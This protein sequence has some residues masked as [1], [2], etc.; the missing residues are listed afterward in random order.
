MKNKLIIFLLTII[1]LFHI[2]FAQTVKRSR[3]EGTI[4][5]PASNVM[6]NGNLTAYADLGGIITSE[7]LEANACIGAGIGIAEILQFNVQTSFI[8]FSR[9]GPTEGHLQA[10]IPG[11]DRLRFF[12]FAFSGDLYLST[13]LDTLDPDADVT[14]PEYNPYPLLSMIADFDFM[15]RPKQ[16]PFKTYISASLADNPRLLFEYKQIAI[17]LGS[18]WKMYQHSIFID[19]GFGLYKEKRNKQLI[20]A[21]YDQKYVWISPGGRYRF[22]KRFSL[23]GNVRWTLYRDIKKNS[24]LNPERIS[25]SVKF[26]APILFKETNTE[27]IRTLVFMEKSRKEEA[28]KQLSK[29]IESENDLL[30][31]FEKILHDLEEEEETFDYKKEKD[32]LIKRR[33]EVEE[34]M[35]EIE[36]L[37][38]EDKE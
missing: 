23:L 12:G 30:N 9:F 19:A 7:E 3:N 27:A 22:G 38:L 15:S 25:L 18:E 26:E 33:E 13:S 4:N 1:S 20:K 36:K 34:K 16:L 37:L 2:D 35:E 31:K 32:E 6:G 11:N 14:K 21:K 17:K 24:S 28:P 5:I 8:N 29:S 10:T